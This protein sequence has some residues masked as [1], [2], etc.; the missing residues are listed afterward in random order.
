MNYYDYTMLIVGIGMAFSILPHIHVM[1]KNKTS[2]GQSLLSVTLFCI[3]IL[4][5]LIYG[6]LHGDYVIT[7]SNSFSL[8]FA[9]MYWSTIYYYRYVYPHGKYNGCYNTLFYFYKRR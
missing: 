6:I 7:I 4:M 9:M 8:I 2:D 1:N 3:G 5:W